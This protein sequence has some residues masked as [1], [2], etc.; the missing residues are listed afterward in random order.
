[1]GELVAEFICLARGYLKHAFVQPS[2][3]GN[4]DTKGGF[5]NTWLELVKEFELVRLMNILLVLLVVVNDLGCHP[6]QSN[7]L[8]HVL[9]FA[10]EHMV[11]SREHSSAS[12]VLDQELED[13]VRDTVAIEGRGAATQLVHN[14]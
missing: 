4:G 11:M 7:L 8:G 2:L 13:A 14:D 10:H 1:M 9:K 5:G 3:S 6:I 12:C